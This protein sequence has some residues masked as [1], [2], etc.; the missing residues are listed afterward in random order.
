[1]NE[2]RGSPKL[3]HRVVVLGRF[4]DGLQHVPVL[5]DL[6]VLQTEDV[7]RGGA[8]SPGEI[9]ITPVQ[10]LGRI[11]P[12]DGSFS[13]PGMPRAIDALQAL[14]ERSRR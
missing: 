11:P 12:D 1:V 5:H 6:A 7:D 4:R 10:M 13:Q 14:E 9:L 2:D 3:E 8:A